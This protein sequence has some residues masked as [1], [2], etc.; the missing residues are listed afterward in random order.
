MTIGADLEERGLLEAF[1]AI[2][3]DVDGPF[4][5]VLAGNVLG[6]A[7]T[8]VAPVPRRKELIDDCSAF[9]VI[10]REGGRFVSATLSA[11]LL[12]VLVGGL[13]LVLIMLNGLSSS[14]GVRV[15]AEHFV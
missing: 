14:K 9:V 1:N 2:G 7:A 10:I 3:F 13:E 12:M 6:R 4:P 8:R 5:M 15:S 11:V